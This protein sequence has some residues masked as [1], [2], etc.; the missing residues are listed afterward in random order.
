MEYSNTRLYSEGE[1]LYTYVDATGA[2]YYFALVERNPQTNEFIMKD[3]AGLGMTL[4]YLSGRQMQEDFLPIKT[5]TQSLLM[6]P[7]I[8]YAI[9]KSKVRK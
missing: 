2:R 4:S 7:V 6:L 8:C 5:E 9:K 3:T 1:I